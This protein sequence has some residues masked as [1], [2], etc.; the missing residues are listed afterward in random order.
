VVGEDVGL[1]LFYPALAALGLVEVARQ[2]FALP[3]SERFGVRAVTLTLVFL[4]LLGKPTLEAA[5]HLRRR[6]FGAVVGTGRA[7]A[8]KTLRRKLAEMARQG[9]AGEFGTA[10]ARRWVEHG[11]IDT[12]YLYVDGHMQ[13]YSGKRR[14]EKVWSTKRRMPLPGIHTYHVG[15]ITGRPLLFVTEQL[16]TNLA[17]A[18]PRIVATIRRGD[19]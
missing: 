5:K 2:N 14:L 13:A 9:R 19:R 17:K 8:V 16:S 18:M 12:A 3:R 10:L 1:T 11:I 7:P 6:A 4:T 15:D